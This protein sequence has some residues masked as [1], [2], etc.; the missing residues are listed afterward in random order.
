MI[1]TKFLNNFCIVI[2][3]LADDEKTLW[4]LCKVSKD[5]RELARRSLIKNYS[6]ESMNERLIEQF[7]KHGKQS[8]SGSKG[9]RCSQTIR[10][11]KKL[12]C[13]CY[14]ESE[15]G[16][17]LVEIRFHFKKNG[18]YI[19]PF[20]YQIS[21]K[22]WKCDLIDNQMN[23]HFQKSFGQHIEHLI[24]LFNLKDLMNPKWDI[25]RCYEDRACI[26]HVIQSGP[27]WNRRFTFL[28][29]DFPRQSHSFHHL[30]FLCSFGMYNRYLLL[31]TRFV[32]KLMDD[33]SPT[34]YKIFDTFDES[35]S[36]QH[37]MNT[38]DLIED[39]LFNICWNE[40]NQCLTFGFENKAIVFDPR[41]PYSREKCIC[42]KLLKDDET[43][44]LDFIQI[45]PDY[46]VKSQ[47]LSTLFTDLVYCEIT[48][49]MV[50]MYHFQIPPV[51]LC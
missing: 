51:L 47:T 4:I 36:K 3:C 9:A 35:W 48:D 31:R 49:K 27:K 19:G 22:V 41:P 15:I 33:R 5:I 11:S 26:Y 50:N 44:E 2:D 12:F 6:I 30:V 43:K 10:H 20:K 21:G 46:N 29:C 40:K 45:K 8:K 37:P 39:Q 38:N 17:D 28:Q 32:P 13:V 24:F 16:K 18:K 34:F 23:I 1:D 7:D 25:T 14:D 42:I